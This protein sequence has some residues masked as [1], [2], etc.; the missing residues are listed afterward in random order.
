MLTQQLSAGPLGFRG[1]LVLEE[2]SGGAAGE[3][4]RIRG[5]RG[6]CHRKT[7]R[8]PQEQP[9]EKQRRQRYQWPSPCLRA[10][11]FLFAC[12]FNNAPSLLGASFIVCI[13]GK[14]LGLW[15]DLN[16]GL[17]STSLQSLQ[18]RMLGVEISLQLL[19]G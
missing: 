5:R 8:D 19:L 14:L 1:A 6:P 3:S 16:S 4:Q 15:G 17:C 2:V 13:F 18:E 10:P 11:R 7:G 12:V 9:G